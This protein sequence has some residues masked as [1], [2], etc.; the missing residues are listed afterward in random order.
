MSW[1]TLFDLAGFQLVW[2]S[3][4]LGASYGRSTPGILAA[5]AFVAIQTTIRWQSIELY[6]TILIA[7]VFGLAAE[8]LLAACGLVQY[9]AA[10]PSH[11]LVPAWIVALWLAFGTTVET[12]HRLLGSRPFL[13]ALLLGAIGGPLAYLAGASVGAL[14]LPTPSGPSLLVIAAIWGGLSRRCWR[15]TRADR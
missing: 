5:A 9:A 2:W 10:W 11:H 8:S 14:S 13:T 12:M 3:C 1:R 4:A 6:R 15:C 7:G